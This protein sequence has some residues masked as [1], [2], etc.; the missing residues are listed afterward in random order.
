MPLEEKKVLP[1]TKEVFTLL[2][3]SAY[4]LDPLFFLDIPLSE[5][6]RSLSDTGHL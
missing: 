6:E 2:F 1:L 5:C 4:R 3:P